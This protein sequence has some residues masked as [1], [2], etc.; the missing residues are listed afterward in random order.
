L[1]YATAA[2][3]PSS[4]ALAGADGENVHQEE[5]MRCERS[6]GVLALA[7][8]LA[9]GS[10]VG[11][12]AAEDGKGADGSTIRVDLNRAS[13]VELTRVPGIGPALAK[14]IVQFRDQH[15]PFQRVEDIMKVRGIGEKSFLK[16]R[17]YLVVQKSKRK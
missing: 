1:L 7:V 5:T 13:E 14:R 15:G 6:L 2:P 3:D 12:T 10:V 11:A 4:S 17:P 9:L 16:L 8:L